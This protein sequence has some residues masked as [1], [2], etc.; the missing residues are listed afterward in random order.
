MLLRRTHA[1]PLF[2]TALLSV[3]FKLSF[4]ECFWEIA[5][6][7]LSLLTTDHFSD[8]LELASTFVKCSG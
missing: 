7:A 8:A 5:K 6:F 2:L 3:M 4:A 1:E